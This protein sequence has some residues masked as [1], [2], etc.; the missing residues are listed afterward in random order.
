MV[1]GTTARSGG[2]VLRLPKRPGWS[3]QAL[4]VV[5]FAAAIVPAASALSGFAQVGELP[6]LARIEVPGGE[7]SELMKVDV[8]MGGLAMSPDGI[9]FGAGWTIAPAAS[10]HLAQLN[11]DTLQW[12]LIGPI[13]LG[14]VPQGSDLGLAF[15]ASGRLWLS[16]GPGGPRRLYQVNRTSGVAT[17]AF[18]LDHFIHGLA[19][20]GRYLFG[21][22]DSLA[23]TNF[24]LVRIDPD[25]AAVTLLRTSSE[26]A[27][28]GGAGMGLD[29][30]HEGRLWSVMRDESLFGPFI[31]G[32]L[33]EFD[34]L[35]GATIS[36]QEHPWT[37][38]V[39]SLALAPPPLSCRGVPPEAVPTL[40]GWSMLALVGV[41]LAVA[42]AT[43][44]RSAAS[45][46]SR[47]L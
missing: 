42:L 35:T 30:D 8:A 6:Y 16:A 41:L 47:R 29:F 11:T 25:S 1:S 36:N 17:L 44:R 33:T 4:I 7:L 23:G 22:G 24:D 31:T 14:S 38:Y 5:A 40:G 15:D 3:A 37:T 27:P 26:T 28:R 9:V 21:I 2:R 13:E 34:P 32:F 46:H 39:G 19:G 45:A 20:C 10:A 12:E 43:L 18:E